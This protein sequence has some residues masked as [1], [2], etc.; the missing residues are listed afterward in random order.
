MPGDDHHH[1]G[2][3]HGTHEDEHEHHI[4]QAGIEMIGGNT[5]TDGHHGHDDHHDDHGH[6]RHNHHDHSHSHH[7]VDDHGDIDQEPPLQGSKPKENINLRAAYLHVLADLV[8]SIAVFIAGLVIMHKPEWSI[9]D[10]ILSI[11]FC[12]IIF[13]STLG[14]IRTSLRILLE[15]SP[16]DVNVNELWSSIASVEGVTKV[17]GVQVWS[18]CHGTTAMTLHARATDPQSVLHK[19]NHICTSRYGIDHCTIQIEEDASDSFINNPSTAHFYAP[20]NSEYE[21]V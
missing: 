3:D 9:I 5:K 10:P 17:S 14:V 18:I 8:Q 19:I 4:S 21:L 1:H 6:E 12:P 13:Y 7:T 11:I 2:H 15:G 20:V 16:P